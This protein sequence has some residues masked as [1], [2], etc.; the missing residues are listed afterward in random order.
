M[1]MY[2]KRINSNIPLRAVEKLL[3]IHWLYITKAESDKCV[4][5]IFIKSDRHYVYARQNVEL[6]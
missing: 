1:L 6:S 4:K 3:N 2:Y 5:Y